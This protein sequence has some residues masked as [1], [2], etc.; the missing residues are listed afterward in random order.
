[1]AE[2]GYRPGTQAGYSRLNGVGR[3]EVS[4]RGGFAGSTGRSWRAAR[5]A[6]VATLASVAGVPAPLLAQDAGTAQTPCPE[7]S[8]PGTVADPFAMARE[9]LCNAGMA[10][11]AA[12]CTLR[13]FER[14]IDLDG[15]AELFVAAAEETGN[16]G[17]LHLAFRRVPGGW[18]YLG[19]LFLHPAAFRVLP[20]AADGLPRM[21]LYLR[22]AADA[23]KL[24]TVT[25]D[26]NRFVLV[27]EE[28]IAPL[29]DDRSRYEQLF[30]PAPPTP[31]P[32][33]RKRSTP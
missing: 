9:C 17:G 7:A 14:D 27:G 2:V 11:A 23:G 8:L 19:S 5:A 1:M 10:D 12:P 15:Q 32:E 22:L 30:A 33:G 28:T 6:L 21:A 20:P 13:P 24:R 18:R 31:P 26:G 16:A 4:V 3:A 25:H 29:G